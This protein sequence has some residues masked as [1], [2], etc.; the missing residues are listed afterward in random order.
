MRIKPWRLYGDGSSCGSKVGPGGWAWIA[1]DH[2][3][4]CRQIGYGGEP[5]T[6]NNIMELTAIHK[7]LEW[8]TT[9]N[10]REIE[11]ISDSQY[12]LGI[13]SGK[14]KPAANLELVKAATDTKNKCIFNGVSI[15]WRWTPGHSGDFWN[16]MCDRLAKAEKEKLKAIAAEASSKMRLSRK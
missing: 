8:L 2:L 16:E 9:A 4:Q 11:V 15:E 7:G 3:N 5:Q 10:I 6:T 1:V 12:C 13:L 14:F